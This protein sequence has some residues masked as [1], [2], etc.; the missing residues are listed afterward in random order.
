MSAC[1]FQVNSP[2][3]ADGFVI[4]PGTYA[5]DV[6][7][8]KD[9]SFELTGEPIT[10]SLYIGPSVSNEPA[11]GGSAKIVDVTQLVETGAVTVID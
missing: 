6:H 9:A 2:C 1:Q 8:R 11:V 4:L 3:T 5:G 10:Y 7:R